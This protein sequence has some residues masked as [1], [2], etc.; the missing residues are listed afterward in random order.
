MKI[1][2]RVTYGEKYGPAM[3]VETV[4]RAAEYFNACVEHTMRLNSKLTREEAESMER[5]S[6]GYWSGYYGREMMKKVRVL[7]GFGHPYIDE[8]DTPEQIIEKGMKLGERLKERD[9]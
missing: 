8:N 5:T 4:E 3:K 9:E 2:D 7:Y 1:P 6:I